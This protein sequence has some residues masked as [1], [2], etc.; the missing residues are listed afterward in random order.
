[1]REPLPFVRALLPGAGDRAK[2]PDRHVGM[3]SMPRLP[4]RILRRQTL[5]AAGPGRKAARGSAPDALTLRPHQ[6]A[7]LALPGALLL[8]FA[9]VVELLAAGERK[10]D[11]GAALFVEIELERHE[12]H[13]LALDRAGELVDLAAVQQEL[14][15]AL[16]RMVEAAALQVFGDV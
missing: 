13:A 5:P 11:L 8:G 1:M 12:G 3:L 2:R 10:L 15:G 16:G 7:A 9:L 6:P 14:A 4:G